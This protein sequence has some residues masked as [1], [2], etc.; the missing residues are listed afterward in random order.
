MNVGTECGPVVVDV[1]Q[2]DFPVT[3]RMEIQPAAYFI[4][5]TVGRSGVAADAGNGGVRARSARQGFDKRSGTPAAQ[6]AVEVTRTEMISVENVLSA[7]HLDDPLAP[8]RNN[9]QQRFE[10]PANRP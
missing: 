1:E 4:R 5:N 2:T 8:L 10:I 7:P 3:G 6:P 9:L